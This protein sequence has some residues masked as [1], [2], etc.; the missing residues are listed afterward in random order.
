[1]DEH[2]APKGLRGKAVPELRLLNELCEQ[3]SLNVHDSVR[4][5][6]FGEWS[7]V[8]TAP[9]G[10]ILKVYQRNVA[11]IESREIPRL[12]LP[13][14]LPIRSGDRAM[15]A[16]SDEVPTHPKPRGRPQ[17]YSIAGR[18]RGCEVQTKHLTTSA[19]AIV[20]DAWPGHT[21]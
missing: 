1:V 2:I 7:E 12:D 17:H 20:L 10:A 5:I 19:E 14:V 3:L 6:K 18:F 4:R 11:A 8:L 13:M 16:L 15:W 21:F 9:P